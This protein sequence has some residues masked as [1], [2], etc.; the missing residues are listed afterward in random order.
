[1]CG[2]V[3]DWADFYDTHTTLNTEQNQLAIK[4]SAGNKYYSN[5]SG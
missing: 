3:M 4:V 2:D 1:M 5:A